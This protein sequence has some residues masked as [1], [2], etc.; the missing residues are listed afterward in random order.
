MLQSLVLLWLLNFLMH[1]YERGYSL[2]GF[3]ACRIISAH[4]CHSIYERVSRFVRIR[5]IIRLLWA[6]RAMFVMLAAS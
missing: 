1:V 6:T 3:M 4:C 2:K 5:S